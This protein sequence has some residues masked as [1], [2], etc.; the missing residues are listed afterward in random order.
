[1]RLLDVFPHK[2][3]LSLVR[4]APL[5]RALTCRAYTLRA[6]ILLKAARMRGTVIALEQTRVRPYGMS[7]KA[8]NVAALTLAMV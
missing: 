3:N 7:L 4:A 2:R 1:M 5:D 8:H 6:L